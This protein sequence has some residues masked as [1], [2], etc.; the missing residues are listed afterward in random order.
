MTRSRLLKLV[1]TPLVLPHELGHALPALLAGLPTTV[2]L[3]PDWEGSQQPLGR[4]N[5]DLDSSTPLWLIR[6]TALAPIPLFV[7]FA[8]LLRLT[9]LPTGL[10]AVSVFL[11]CSF[12]AAPS[13]GDLAIARRPRQAQSAG[14][15]LATAT[16]REVVIADVAT[17]VVS[18]V[19]ALVILA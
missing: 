8:A 9:I 13:G 19:I 14:E 16:V 4:F 5:A 2:T 12:W 7:G 6:V 1:V 18:V 15:L 11:L 10:L 17:L 3:L